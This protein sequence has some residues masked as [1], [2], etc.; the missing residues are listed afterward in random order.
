[1]CVFDVQDHIRIQTPGGGGYGYPE[2]DNVGGLGSSLLNFRKQQQH[3][4]N[5][6]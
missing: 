1:M 4:E 5:N 2:S 6:L 3:V